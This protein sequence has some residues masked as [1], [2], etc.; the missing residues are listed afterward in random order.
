MKARKCAAAVLLAVLLLAGCQPST[1]ITTLEAVV[2]SAEIALPVIAAAAG[3][4]PATTA[5]IVQYLQLVDV[6]I[7]RA[8]VILASSASSADKA[9]QIGVAFAGIAAGCNCIPPGTPQTVVAVVNAVAQAVSRFLAT[10][11][12]VPGP[13]GIAPASVPEYK[14]SGTD[15]TALVK[16]RRRAEKNLTDLK[17]VKP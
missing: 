11:G 7:T 12:A 4:P 9:A 3:I 16:I 5:A 8:S 10:M 14:P 1:V 6:A 13:Q 15:R 17:G 2:A